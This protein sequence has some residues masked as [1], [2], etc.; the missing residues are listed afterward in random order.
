MDIGEV[1]AVADTA[2][3]Q[4]E[5]IS[6]EESGESVRRLLESMTVER[7]RELLIR[8]YL[9]DDDKEDIC[10][11]LN[12]SSLHFNRVLFRAK[13]RFRKILEESANTRTASRSDSG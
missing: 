4:F 13:A 2:P 6:S 9:N 1:A 11:D 12:L 5:R 8:F 7:D 3:R 10:R